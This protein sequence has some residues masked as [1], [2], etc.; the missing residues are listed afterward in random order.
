M[1]LWPQEGECTRVR[2]YVENS[3]FYNAVVNSVIVYDK[4]AVS[5]FCER[6]Y[7]EVDTF[8][9][10]FGEMAL[11]PD[12]A[13]QILGLQ[14][15]GKDEGLS[16]MECRYAAAAY[17]LYVLASVGFPNTKGNRVSANLLQLLDPLEDVNKYSWGSAIVAHMNGQL[18]Q[19]SRERT[20]QINGILALIQVWIYDHFPSLFKD[21]EDVQ[22][23]PK[24]SKGSPSGTRYL[25]TGSQDREQTEALIEMR[26]KLDNITLPVL[27]IGNKLM[28]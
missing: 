6:Y 2:N 26:Q 9:L 19:A 23:N 28:R 17:L 12:D 22:L 25:F 21:N 7:G 14:V 8:Q 13:Y 1:E 10:P 4:V 27:R 5:S 11:T 3:G 18:F 20:S 24:W 15:E 16:N